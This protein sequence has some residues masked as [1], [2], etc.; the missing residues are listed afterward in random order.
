VSA[1]VL[2]VQ[3]AAPGRIGADLIAMLALAGSAVVGE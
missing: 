1:A 3:D 2:V